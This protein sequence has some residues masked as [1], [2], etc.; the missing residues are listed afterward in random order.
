M[1]SID[2]KAFNVAI[3]SVTEMEDN[4]DR[5]ISIDFLKR[6]CLAYEAAKGVER[7]VERSEFE[8]WAQLGS[9]PYYLTKGG[10]GYYFNKETQNAW[11]GWQ[12][13]FAAKASDHPDDCSYEVP[14]RRADHVE[15]MSE[16]IRICKRAMNKTVGEPWVALDKLNRLASRQL[17]LMKTPMI[18]E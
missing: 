4:L 5:D 16:I 13:A 6:L 18:D 2:Q 10:A 1:T 11:L 7:P 3:E 12:G 8:A 9:E 17:L 15:A 14:F